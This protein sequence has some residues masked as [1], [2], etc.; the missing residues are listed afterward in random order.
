LFE[1]AS[2]PWG[3]LALPVKLAAALQIN[4]EHPAGDRL[5]ECVTPAD[6]G[7]I[8]HQVRPWITTD[9]KKWTF[10]TVL[11]RIDIRLPERL[12]FQ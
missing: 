10:E 5:E 7:M 11:R 8:E 2:G 12:A 3:A 1:P 4:A 9:E 6:L